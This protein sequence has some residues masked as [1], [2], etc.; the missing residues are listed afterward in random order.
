MIDAFRVSGMSSAVSYA[1]VVILSLS[2]SCAS[3]GRAPA[4]DPVGVALA[5]AKARGWRNAEVLRCVSEG[6]GMS[7]VH[8]SRNP[9]TPG[10]SIAFVTVDSRGNIVKFDVNSH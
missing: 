10:P 1:L 2:L 5:E 8:I 4:N 9:L 7:R 6:N 3:R